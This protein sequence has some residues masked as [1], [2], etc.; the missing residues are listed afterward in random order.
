[1]P[2]VFYQ[3]S[4]PW[5]P[6]RVCGSENGLDLAPSSAHVKLFCFSMS[7]YRECPMYKRKT[8]N[9]KGT[10][11]WYRFLKQSARLLVGHSK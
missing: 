4:A 7:A 11:R 3:E 5:D 1:M 10:N 9:S 2:C 8:S 6:L